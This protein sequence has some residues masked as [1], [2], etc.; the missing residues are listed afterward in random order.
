MTERKPNDRRSK[1]DRAVDELEPQIH[2]VEQQDGKEVHVFDFTAPGAV[3]RLRNALAADLGLT[4]QAE[5]DAPDEEEE[6]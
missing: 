1:L 2:S 6:Q 5:A 3:D 4:G